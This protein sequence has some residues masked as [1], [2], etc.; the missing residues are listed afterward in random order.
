MPPVAERNPR[1][2][3]NAPPY[4]PELRAAHREGAPICRHHSVMHRPDMMHFIL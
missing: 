4:Y 1:V 3:G 2:R